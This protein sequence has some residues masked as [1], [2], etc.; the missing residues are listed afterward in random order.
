MVYLGSKNR[1]GSDIV[2]VITKDMSESDNFIDAFCGG[3]NLIDKVPTTFNRVANDSNQYLIAMW[4]ALISGWEP[5]TRI[6]RDYYN[7]AREVYNG[8][9]TGNFSDY[10]IGWIG[11]VGSY[12]GKFFGGYSGHSVKTK[13]GTTRDYIKEQANNIIK[14]LP[15]LTNITYL[16]GDYSNIPLTDPEHTVIYC[17]I[18]YKDKTGYRTTF[19]YPNFYDWVRSMTLDGFK[20]YVSEYSMP[21]DFKC[22][23]SAGIRNNMNQDKVT[24]KLFTL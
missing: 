1:I 3:C 23:W 17:D 16:T 13:T 9:G 19:D 6:E 18:P 8:L 2:G 5:P 15:T 24:E 12:S 20:V 11:F 4:K 21:T 14:Q 7:R 22:V 10:E